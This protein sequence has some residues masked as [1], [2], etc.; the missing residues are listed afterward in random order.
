MIRVDVGKETLFALEW[1]YLRSS[2]RSAM[3]EAITLSLCDSRIKCVNQL[4][5]SPKTFLK[6]T[7]HKLYFAMLLTTLAEMLVANKALLAGL[8]GEGRMR[9]GR[10]WSAGRGF[11]SEIAIGNDYLVFQVR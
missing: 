9:A 2:K 10:G 7:L 4:R 6:G 1:R 5:C 3:R 11:K 8:P